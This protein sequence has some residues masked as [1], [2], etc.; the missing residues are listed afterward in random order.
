MCNCVCG[1]MNI[2]GD[3]SL[4]PSADRQGDLPAPEEKAG[5][6]KELIEPW[7]FFS[8]VWSVGASTKADDRRRFSVWLREKMAEE[9]VRG[10][11]SD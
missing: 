11:I 3:G 9:R 8:L 1:R 10:I 4:N 6:L 5:R 2:V 7:F